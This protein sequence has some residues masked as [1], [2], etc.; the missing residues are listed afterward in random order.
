MGAS[1]ASKGCRSPVYWGLVVGAPSYEAEGIRFPYHSWDV[2]AATGTWNVTHRYT[3][4]S[5]D[6]GFGDMVL[7]H[8]SELASQGRL[9]ESAWV[10]AGRA[11]LSRPYGSLVGKRSTEPVL[12]LKSDECAF[13][14]SAGIGKNWW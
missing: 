4:S 8:W 5:E 9:H 2:E 6:S 13:W 14:Q 10:N 12:D 7:G 11:G 1:A 3:P